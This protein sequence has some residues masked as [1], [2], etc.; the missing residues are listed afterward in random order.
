MIPSLPALV[1]SLGKEQHKPP[2]SVTKGAAEP[3][4]RCQ[5]ETALT[6]RGGR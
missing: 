2:P 1:S 3:G 4:I 6:Y 5:I